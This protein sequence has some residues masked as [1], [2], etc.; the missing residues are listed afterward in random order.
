MLTSLHKLKGLDIQATD[1]TIGHIQD[2]YFDDRSWVVRYIVA[3]TGNWLP[4]QLVLLSP[5]SLTSFDLDE[6]VARFDLTREQ[7]EQSPSIE[8]DAPVSRQH[9]TRLAHY[10]G[11]PMYWTTPMAYPALGYAPVARD[12][13]AESHLQSDVAEDVNKNPSLRSFDEV[14]RYS[15]QTMDDEFGHLEDLLAEPENWEVHYMVIDTRKW[16]PGRKILASVHWIQ[17]I[18]WADRDIVVSVTRDQVKTSPELEDIET[19]D[20][21]TEVQLHEHYGL[22]AYWEQTS[23][24]K[25]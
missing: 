25:R 22:P 13:T 16:L 2:F 18:D 12:E 7:I 11:W 21:E 19:L 10:Y 14:T 17:N 6:G 20:R 24:Q 3:D 9:E 1:D 8:T 15:I 4:G 23:P 5:Q